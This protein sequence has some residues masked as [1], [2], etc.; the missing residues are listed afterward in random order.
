MDALYPKRKP[1]INLTFFGVILTKFTGSASELIE[2]VVF[3]TN[4]SSY[5]TIDFGKQTT[6]QK[7]SVVAI[8]IFFVSNFPIKN[9]FAK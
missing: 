1:K 7:L 6:G 2:G 9:L 4:Y 8:L 3:L 5:L